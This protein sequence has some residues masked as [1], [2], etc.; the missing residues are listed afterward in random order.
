MLFILLFSRVTCKY[1]QI[2]YTDCQKVVGYW[3]VWGEWGECHCKVSLQKESVFYW[4]QKTFEV[5]RYGERFVKERQRTCYCGKDG[6][7]RGCDSWCGQPHNYIDEE[8]CSESYEE[9]WDNMGPCDEFGY[10]T[11]SSI[12]FRKTK[13]RI[14]ESDYRAN[15][16]D[17]KIRVQDI[18]IKKCTR[19]HVTV[20]HCHQ[21]KSY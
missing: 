14:S 11:V 6:V 5:T 19:T 9:K 15:I 2:D 7:E 20:K 8:R 3:S 18:L 12:Y 10:R 16:Q 21:L 4:N 1:Y 13:L 17:V